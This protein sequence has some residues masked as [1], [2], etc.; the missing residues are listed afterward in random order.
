[1]DRYLALLI[2]HILAD[3]PLQAGIIYTWK[4]S[5]R[6]G[7]GVHVAIHMIVMLLMFES[8]QEWWPALVALGIVHYL[9]DWAKLRFPIQPQV[10][11]YI[12]DQALHAVSLIPIAIVFDQMRPAIPS[13]FLVIDFLLAVIP[14]ILLMFWTYT[15][16]VRTQEPITRPYSLVNW[17]RRSLLPI[18]QWTG[19][20]LIGAIAVQ[21]LAARF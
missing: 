14:P 10:L 7:L 6:L 21:V 17:A 9:I 20:I 2:A 11:G 15:W 5:S 18:S 16:D 3:F 8:P 19:F 13:R 1:M 4:T 12:V